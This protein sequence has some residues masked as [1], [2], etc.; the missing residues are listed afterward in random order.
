M[1]LPATFELEQTEG[2]DMAD[3][4]KTYPVQPGIWLQAGISTEQEAHFHVYGPVG[5]SLSRGAAEFAPGGLLS[6][7]T[8][9]NVFNYGKW[10]R[11]C[12]DIPL[13][14]QLKGKGHFQLT[15]FQA[16]RHK[17]WHK[18][19]SEV[20][21]LD[22]MYRHPVLVDE[23]TPE[24]SLLF[25]D[26]MALQDGELEDF[27][28]ATTAKPVRTPE[29]ML[30]VTTFKR[31]AEVEDTI[32]RFREFLVDSAIKE[33]ISMTVVDNGNSLKVEDGGGVEVIPNENLGGAGGFTRGLLRAREIGATHCLFMDDDASIQMEAL[34]RTWWLLAYA[35]DSRTAVAGAMINASHRWQIWENGAEFDLGCKPRY[36]GLDLRSRDAVFEMEY[37][38]TI[39]APE[40]LYAGWWF[41]AFPLDKVE[42]LPFPFFV[43]GDDV[44]FSLVNDFDIVSLPGVASV[45]ENFTDKASPMTWYLDFRSHLVHHLSLP[46]KQ[47]SWIE[48]QQMV[49]SFYQRNVMRF[50]YDT[51]SAINLA[52]ED[53]L[54]GPKF[55][56]KHADM[57]RRRSD[58]KAL[59]K[60]EAWKPVVERPEELHGEKSRLARALLLA[61]LNGHL[62]PMGKEGDA[63]L[64]LSSPFRDDYHK[65]YGAKQ[66]TYLNG[67][68][69]S[70]YVVRRSQKKFWRETAR[71]VRNTMR[72]RAT[73]E[74]NLRLWRDGYDQ[75]TSDAY[76][77][78]KLNLLGDGT[79]NR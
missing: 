21:T 26:L 37:E 3:S 43:R 32:S 18:L 50:H 6:T 30:S 10:K 11:I 7:G 40:D 48:L 14:L 19:V 54:R 46:E 35:R 39:P 51:L 23:E 57:A 17:S 49:L 79:Q 77:T 24:E 28:W 63:D 31:E 76:W 61:S 25:F 33:H 16:D 41:F 2:P 52:F 42:H 5:I 58:L 4:T 1:T 44:S 64:T 20:V 47:R 67:D 66:I 9:Y 70:A 62:L 12:G 72:L 68:Q 36:H 8:Y 65:V 59:T 74:E 73:Y 13:E 69:S 45:Q 53:V 34:S 27:A 55:F 60:Q 71:L 75:L 38:T 15:V 78:E 29:L 56:D 22:G